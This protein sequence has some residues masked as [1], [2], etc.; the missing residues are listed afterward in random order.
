VLTGGSP[1]VT[2]VAR[3]STF[4]YYRFNDMAYGQSYTIT[5]LQKRYIFTP[6]SI[7]RNHGSEI[8]NLDFI[9]N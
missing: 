9:G 3:T 7:I 2:L 5:P 8:T 4:G 1:S 6:L